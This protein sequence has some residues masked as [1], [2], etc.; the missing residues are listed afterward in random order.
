MRHEVTIK[1]RTTKTYTR[2]ARASYLEG[3]TCETCST[4]EHV[5]WVPNAKI[6]LDNSLHT[7]SKYKANTHYT[8]LQQQSVQIHKYRS[9]DTKIS[10]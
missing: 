10:K 7:N 8:Y 4:F 2:A 1:S 9:I 3:R 6:S 5:L